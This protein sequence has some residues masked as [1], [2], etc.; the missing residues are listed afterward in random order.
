MDH[1]DTILAVDDNNV[2]LV[3]LSAM[4]AT[5]YNVETVNDAYQAV[6][7]AARDIPDLI[8]LDVYMPGKDGL[9]ICRDLKAN[10]ATASIPVIIVSGRT[11]N[12]EVVAGLEAGADDY[13]CK[14][15]ST[16]ELKIRIK[17][18][19][20][21]T[22]PS[23]DAAKKTAE[24]ESTR[25]QAQD[26]ARMLK[27]LADQTNE[28]IM[29]LDTENNIMAASSAC[30]KV[31]G[32]DGNAHGNI[33]DVLT[34]D[35]DIAN[36]MTLID[37]ITDDG[38]PQSARYMASR[39][40]AEMPILIEASA[41]K[42]KHGESHLTVIN[43]REIR[44]GDVENAGIQKDLEMKLISQEKEIA[45]Y[46]KYSA[47]GIITIKENL[48]L[49]RYNKRFLE[50][51]G[52]NLKKNYTDV[53]LSNIMDSNPLQEIK[54]LIQKV[55]RPPLFETA[56]ITS[57]REDGQKVFIEATASRLNLYGENSILLIFTDVTTLRNMDS[58]ILSATTAA[59][60]H[61]RTMLAQELHDGIGA[62]LSSMNIYLNM[63][64]SGGV[65]VDEIFKNI[66]L[67]KDLVGQCIESVKEIANN[68]HPVILTRFGLVETIQS[69]ID[70]LQSSRLI[71]FQFDHSGF[72]RISNKDLELS[73]YRMLNEMLSNTMKYAEASSVDITLKTSENLLQISYKDNGKGFSLQNSNIQQGKN[74]GLKNIIGRVKALNGKCD[75][76]SEPC[77]GVQIEIEIPYNGNDN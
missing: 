53:S 4:L 52:I 5:E 35:D 8:L 21:L 59:E 30:Q 28:A 2:N 17:R 24:I 42:I 55:G 65:E 43:A 33:A 22:K 63:I 18:L 68:L 51:F 74:M 7:R 36:L 44:L 75:I 14:P 37:Q 72:Q 38:T 20:R 40:Y 26:Q 3:M 12:Q 57:T 69:I 66:R 62:T 39:I 64:L 34:S 31:L 9:S 10:P 15:F 58:A 41:K 61:E 73:I 67:T 70:E 32:M 25:N 27:L 56:S 49:K 1:K 19:I 29:L 76:K 47:N 23:T 45:G 16:N 71:K 46:F 77:K 6:D 48:V 54:Q 60:E 11:S 13:I 50:I